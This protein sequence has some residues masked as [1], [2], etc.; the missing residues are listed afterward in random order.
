MNFLSFCDISFL[1]SRRKQSRYCGKLWIISATQEHNYDYFLWQKL[2]Q[3]Q[4]TQ[5]NTNKHTL[6]NINK[7]KHQQQLL[8]HQRQQQD[9]LIIMGINIKLQII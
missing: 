4:Q 8:Q 5:T 2:W 6:L 7:H 9:Q 3:T 1:F